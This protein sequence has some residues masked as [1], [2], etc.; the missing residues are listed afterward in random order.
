MKKVF[1]LICVPLSIAL[2]GCGLPPEAI[3]TAVV[4]GTAG[5]VAA[6]GRTPVDAVISLVSGKDCS[7]VRLEQHKTYCRPTEPKPPPPV[8]C[9]R[10]LGVVNCW[11]DPA[12]LPDQPHG[13]ADGPSVLTP[14]QE[15]DRTRR[16]P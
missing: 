7:A 13:V 5:S 1:W 12:A 8:F 3:A 4:G 15:A 11:S 9:T 14:Q 16:W 10:T 2:A 6:I